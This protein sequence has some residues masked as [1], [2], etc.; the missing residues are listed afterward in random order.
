MGCRVGNPR[1]KCRPDSPRG[2][3]RVRI[4]VGDDL[5]LACGLGRGLGESVH[6]DI[7]ITPRA[8][9][10]VLPTLP[11]RPGAAIFAV[12]DGD[13]VVGEHI[14]DL[15]CGPPIL[16]RLGLGSHVYDEIKKRTGFVSACS[17]FCGIGQLGLQTKDVCMKVSMVW[18]SAEMSS[19]I[20][21]HVSCGRAVDG[22]DC[23]EQRG[24]QNR[25]VEI[26]VHGCVAA[27]AERRHV[28]GALALTRGELT[29]GLDGFL[30]LDNPFQR[31]EGFIAE[32]EVLA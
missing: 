16:V 23:V 30:Q 6:H 7:Q 19:P 8:T 24:D 1:T 11:T 10:S 17:S 9:Q 21:G 31:L 13:A 15:I 3:G 25:R 32:V 14:P 4:E 26:V 2:V 20:E 28:V 12:L 22:F 27:S 5:N 29:Q 18:V